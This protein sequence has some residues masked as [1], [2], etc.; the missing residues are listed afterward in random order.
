M[1]FLDVMYVQIRP[2]VQLVDKIVLVIITMDALAER[3]ALHQNSD[4]FLPTHLNVY[5]FPNII[6]TRLRE[7]VTPVIRGALFVKVRVITA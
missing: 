6:S 3:H 4:M 1:Q 2:I 5:V 7:T